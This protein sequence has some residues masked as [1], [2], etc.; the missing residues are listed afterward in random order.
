MEYRVHDHVHNSPRPGPIRKNLVNI[1]ITC[2]FKI[3]FSIILSSTPKKNFPNC[4]FNFKD[5]IEI[6][7]FWTPPPPPPPVSS[8]P[9]RHV[10][11]IHHSSRSPYKE[12]CN[13]DNVFLL[14]HLHQ[15]YYIS[16]KEFQND[17]NYSLPFHSFISLFPLLRFIRFK[18]LTFKNCFD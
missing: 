1:L 8:S 16:E 14:M 7:R 4:L 3:H 13:T 10:T 12:T 6:K 18:I 9:P 17:N 2:S 5:N 11:F 15:L